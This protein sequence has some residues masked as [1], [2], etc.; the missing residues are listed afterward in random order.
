MAKFITVTNI[1]Q[2][3]SINDCP[4]HL[5]KYHK[6]Y[7]DIILIDS[8]VEISLDRHYF[9]NNQVV[10]MPLKPSIH[11]EFDYVNKNW[12]D[13]RTNETQWIVVKNK[14]D[15]LLLQTDWTDTYSAATR[16]GDKYN[17]WQEYRQALRDITN[18]P[19]PF[20]ITWPVQPQ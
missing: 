8:E 6:N 20:N 9:F 18:Q 12:I 19:D 17:I 16:L 7:P 1:G 4:E 2:I 10:T 5:I 14:R 11:H 15:E 3:T 13:P